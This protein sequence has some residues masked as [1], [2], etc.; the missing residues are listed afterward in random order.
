MRTAT[1]ILVVVGSRSRA[2]D[3]DPVRRL[4]SERAQWGRRSSSELLPQPTAFACRISNR[5]APIHG[6][7]AKSLKL[8]PTVPGDL[9][10]VWTTPVRRARRGDGFSLSSGLRR[11][12]HALAASSTT[13]A[14]RRC[15]LAFVVG[16][17]ARS[18]SSRS[19]IAGWRSRSR[20]ASC[21]GLEQRLERAGGA[22]PAGRVELPLGRVGRADE[23]RVVGVRKPVRLGRAS[24]RSRS[25][26]RARAPR[27]RHRRRGGSPRS[28]PTPSRRRAR[29]RRAR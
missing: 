6:S 4:V 19:D 2:V 22:Q 29:R 9:P 26:P 17:L 13:F 28:P 27:R 20:A 24:P 14:S 15:M 25:A 18:A 8:E 11:A 5:L 3:P 7:H 21:S 12:R 1:L 23:V 16:G 10:L